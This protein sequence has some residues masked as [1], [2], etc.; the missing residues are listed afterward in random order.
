MYTL[1]DYLFFRG[2]IGFD[3]SPVNEVDEMVFSVLGKADFTDILKENEIG[4]Y[5]EVFDRFFTAKDSDETLR[6]GLLSS[7]VLMKVLR[8]IALCPRYADLKI[9]NFV[10]RVSAEN[11]EQMSALTVLGPNDRIYVTFRGTDDTLIGWKENC[12]LA[13]FDSVPAQRDAAAYLEEI[14]AVFKGPIR[15]TGH[16]KGGNL[17][18]YA[19]AN[20]SEETRNRIEKVVSYDGP[21]FTNEF[22][23]TPGYISVKDRIETLVPTA[24]IVGMLMENAGALDVIT[25]EKEG[26]MAH[27]LFTWNLGRDEFLR[28]EGLSEKSISFREAIRKALEQADLEERKEMVDELFEALSSTGAERLLDFTDNTFAQALK[29]AGNFRKSKELKEFI[30]DLSRFFLREKAKNR[31][32]DIHEALLDKVIDP[33]K[34]KIEVLKESEL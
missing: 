23:E 8:Q 11:T 25:S 14:A 6:L 27:D 19:A 21:G 32:E 15:V 7:K 30:S 29:V 10:N 26:A 1:E 22:L 20:A 33:V 17:A 2:D 4:R 16:S 12:D 3:I 5:A 28:A 24:S 18:I 31:L 13:I 34:G 9:C